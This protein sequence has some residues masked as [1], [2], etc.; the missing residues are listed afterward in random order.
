[1]ADVSRMQVRGRPRI[2]WMDGVKVAFGSRVTTVMPPVNARKIR[3]GDPWW[4]CR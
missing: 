1:M 4:T 3:S 2:S